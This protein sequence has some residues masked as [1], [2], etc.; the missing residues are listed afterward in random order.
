MIRL[1]VRENL[2][3]R[4]NIFN[5]KYAFSIKFNFVSPKKALIILFIAA[6]VLFSA[7]LA[8][9]FFSGKN[10]P[11]NDSRA[12]AD[13]TGKSPDR[14]Q[15]EKKDLDEII[16]KTNSGQPLTTEESAVLDEAINEKAAEK[17]K[18]VQEAARDRKY[19]QDEIIMLFSPKQAVEAEMGIKSGS[20]TG[21][22]KP[23]TE[24]EIDGMFNPKN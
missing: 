21:E 6:A 7:F 8:Y 17:V 4:K 16:K 11:W 9:Y 3:K 10:S 22:V 2:L 24:E 12:P 15:P 19:A 18:A 13:G 1:L 20:S 14:I 23:L 5:Y